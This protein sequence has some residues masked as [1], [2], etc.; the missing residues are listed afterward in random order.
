M[1]LQ[2]G[3]DCIPIGN[4]HQSKTKFLNFPLEFIVAIFSLSQ[5]SRYIAGDMIYCISFK[6]T[7]GLLFETNS[8]RQVLAQC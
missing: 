4:G 6:I 1:S 8:I 3:M 7:I 2:L 5:E